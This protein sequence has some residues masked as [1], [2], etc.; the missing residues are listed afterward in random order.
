MIHHQ[1]RATLT[2]ETRVR[3]VVQST[4]NRAIG[5]GFGIPILMLGGPDTQHRGEAPLELTFYGYTKSDLLAVLDRV[6]GGIEAL[7]QAIVDEHD[8]DTDIVAAGR[9]E[10]VA[11]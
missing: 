11:A 7:R 10:A 3:A 1:T 5:D 2:A 6:A 9:G 8:L 4:G